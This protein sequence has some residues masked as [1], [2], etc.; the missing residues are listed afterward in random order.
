MLY[1]MMTIQLKMPRTPR[2]RLRRLRRLQLLFRTT[3]RS[4]STQE[5]CFRPR[6]SQ[7]RWHHSLQVSTT[8]GGEV[9]ATSQA[10]AQYLGVA[11]VADGYADVCYCSEAAAWHF[12]ETRG[13]GGGGGGSKSNIQNVL[14]ITLKISSDSGRQTTPDPNFH[15]AAFF[16]A[17]GE[18][19]LRA[20]TTKLP[21]ELRHRPQFTS[22]R[23]PR[24]AFQKKPVIR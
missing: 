8:G 18:L 16:S 6:R 19:R 7:P 24:L 5:V 4:S 2:L 1:L 23:L 14:F 9:C 20:V 22:R 21:A 3:C 15:D 10:N 12:C 13:W 11:R 17:R